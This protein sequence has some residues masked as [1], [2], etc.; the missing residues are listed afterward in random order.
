MRPP[1]WS[2]Q[3]ALSALRD[4]PAGTV[5]ISS[6]EHAADLILLA[7]IHKPTQGGYGTARP[8]CKAE[9]EA[10]EK[11][12]YTSYSSVDRENQWRK[13]ECPMT[14]CR[15]SKTQLMVDRHSAGAVGQC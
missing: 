5:R 4:K 14:H 9:V 3:A 15:R 7:A 1:R 11:V 13:V 6:S 2:R 10:Y 8:W 12:R